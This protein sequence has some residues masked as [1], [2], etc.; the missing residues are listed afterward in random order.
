VVVVVRCVRG[1]ITAIEVAAVLQVRVCVQ[2]AL[3]CIGLHNTQELAVH[4]FYCAAAVV[5]AVVARE[6]VQNHSL[7]GNHTQEHTHTEVTVAA[8]AVVLAVV[9]VDSSRM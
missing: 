1:G 7:N 3:A 8:A 9:A 6:T 5:A 4:S 2:V